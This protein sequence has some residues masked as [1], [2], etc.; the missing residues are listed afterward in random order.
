LLEFKRIPLPPKEFMEL[1]C[2]LNLQNLS[3]EFESVG[4]GLLEMLDNEGMLVPGT[5]FL[6]VGCGCGR[7]ARYL[8]S[9]P[10]ES[11]T[12]F[13]RHPGMIKWCQ[14]EITRHASRF[15]FQCF[16]IKSAYFIRD[17]Y[18]GTIKASSFRFPFPDQSF[19]FTLLSSVFTHMPL[20]E[21]AHYLKEIYRVLR[22]NGKALVSVFFSAKK[23][24]SEDIGFLYNPRAY[25]RTVSEAG[26]S[27]RQ[28]DET[29]FGWIH[30]WHIL[31]KEAVT[32]VPEQE[33]E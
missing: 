24:Y 17:G 28:Y 31:S 25:W 11:Y 22:P 19:D 23:P 6:D 8:L 2:G 33:V 15:L 14:D 13:D 20:E 16:D 30:N 12:G 5:R 3:E 27:H 7:V 26:F 21:S 9:K 1:V 4:K 32:D 10:I 29:R 18:N